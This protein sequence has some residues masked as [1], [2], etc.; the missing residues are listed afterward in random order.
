MN[1]RLHSL[2]MF[3]AIAIAAPYAWAEDNALESETAAQFQAW[4]R[5]DVPGG[6]TAIV[7]D[8]R[9]IF[10]RGFGSANLDDRAPITTQ[11]IFEMGSISK[12]FVCAALAVLMDQGK[13]GTEDDI[14]KYVPE[15]PS[16][17]PPILVRHL[18]RCESGLPDYWF[19]MQLAGRNIEDAYT[20]ADV[21][22]LLTRWKT[23]P[24]PGSR[25]AYSSSDYVLLGLIIERVS[26]KTLADFT[27]EN[28]FGPLEMTRT[29]F[30]DEPTRPVVNRVVGYDKRRAGGYRRWAIN[31]RVV[32]G[33]GLKSCIEDQIRWLANFD[34][35]RLPSGPFLDRFLATGTLL[36]NRNV[37]DMEPTG[38]YRG[39]KRIQFTGGLPGFQAA[40]VRYPNQRFAVI[41]LSNSDLNP[42]TNAR[43]IADRHLA[44]QFTAPAATSPPMADSPAVSVPIEDLQ[45]K[46]GDYELLDG[47]I[48]KIAVSD[49]MLICDNYVHDRMGLEPLNATLFRTR[50]KSG[51]LFQFRRDATNGPFMLNVSDADGWRS[52]CRPVELVSPGKAQLEECSGVFF[53]EGLLATYRFAVR[54]GKLHLQVNN[55]GWEPLDS[56]TRD[57]FVPHVRSNDDNRIIQFLRNDQG[58]VNVA[59]V[60]L[61]RVRGVRLLKQP[62][63]DRQIDSPTAQ[64]AEK[65]F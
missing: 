60:D 44:S 42:F 63:E 5:P 33:A 34:S 29:Y 10:T 13:V 55:R 41:C 57:R 58:R 53:N 35:N 8:G 64:P 65:K 7:R 1:A 15:M 52:E 24:P 14:R 59:T 20:R 61:W 19:A 22:A 25:F 39:L 38:S 37:L 45:N 54:G 2:A 56:T 17:D 49:G 46:V 36:D 32:G 23:L 6:A 18:V 26:G 62:D 4:D 9:I 48:W 47:R 31:A 40:V 16:R 30:E 12:S 43:L 28:L 3:L 50:D 51:D 21:L 11:S 27:R